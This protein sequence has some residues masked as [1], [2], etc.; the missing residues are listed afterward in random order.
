ML[1]ISFGIGYHRLEVGCLWESL[2]RVT[3]HTVEYFW[4]P[5]KLCRSHWTSRGKKLEL[6]PR[7]NAH[8]VNAL[9][10]AFTVSID[11]PF[12]LN[13]ECNHHT[14]DS[15]ALKEIVLHNGLEKDRWSSLCGPKGQIWIAWSS[16]CSS[17]GHLFWVWVIIDSLLRELLNYSAQNW[18][19]PYQGISVIFWLLMVHAPILLELMGWSPKLTLAQETNWGRS[20]LL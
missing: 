10:D 8:I 2:M 6:N 9:A 17:C 14:N 5:E 16:T 12:L 13:L 1:N 18:W 20:K 19:L 3:F 15:E 7:E 11:A 4:V